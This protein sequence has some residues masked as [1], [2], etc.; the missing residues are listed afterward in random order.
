MVKKSKKQKHLIRYSVIATLIVIAAISSAGFFLSNDRFVLNGFRHRP[1]FEDAGKIQTTKGIIQIKQ[2]S[3]GIE[4]VNS[5][6]NVQKEPG[7][8]D[9]GNSITVNDIKISTGGGALAS[10]EPKYTTNL[11]SLHA[12]DVV[13]VRYVTDDNGYSSTN[14]A[15]CFVK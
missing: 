12:G 15:S 2:T 5:F 7:I 8:C 1:T 4:K 14:C 10:R 9:S 6:G 11:E 3:C 13:E